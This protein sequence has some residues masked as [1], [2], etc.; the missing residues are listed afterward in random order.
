MTSGRL[1]GID[2]HAINT[3]AGVISVQTKPLPTVAAVGSILM[4]CG[5][6]VDPE[7]ARKHLAIDA[8]FTYLKQAGPGKGKW[9]PPA[10][11]TAG[12]RELHCTLW[13]EQ[14]IGAVVATLLRNM[15]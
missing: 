10:A 8:F 2:N 5:G 3:F 7:V 11:L 12:D 9:P 4:S 15:S 6:T 14:L 1:N 13:E